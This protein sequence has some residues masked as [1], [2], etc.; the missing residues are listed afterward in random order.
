MG[1][2]CCKIGH[3]QTDHVFS[4]VYHINQALQNIPCWCTLIFNARPA[5]DFD[6]DLD[7]VAESHADN[8][9]NSLAD[10][11]AEQARS[12]LLGEMAQNLLKV[13]LET[14]IKKSIGLIQNKHFEG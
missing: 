12:P 3:L 9:I 5:F 7:G 13:L 1:W 14:E 8:L 10:T 6:G 4:I 2:R 11:G